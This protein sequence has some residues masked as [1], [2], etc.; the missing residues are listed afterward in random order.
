MKILN[1]SSMAQLVRSAQ[2]SIAADMVPKVSAAASPATS[3]NRVGIWSHETNKDIVNVSS[4]PHSLT[5][6]PAIP[7][8]EAPATIDAPAERKQFG[9]RAAGGT[10]LSASNT[11]QQRDVFDVD[12]ENHHDSGLS[13]SLETGIWTATSSMPSCEHLDSDQFYRVLPMSFAQTRFWFLKHLVEDQTAFNV[14]TVV[15]LK[16]RVDSTRLSRAL[17]AVGTRHEAIRTAFFTNESDSYMQGVLPSL[18][19]QLEEVKIANA[20]NVQG[21]IRDI[22]EHEFDLSRGESIRL[23]LVSLREKEHW[24]VLGYHHIAVDGIG[25]RIFLSDLERA[26]YN[27]LDANDDSVLQYPDFSIRQRQEYEQGA[28]SKQIG[29]WRAQFPDLPPPLPVLHLAGRESRPLRSVFSSHSAKLVLEPELKRSIA[30]CCRRLGVTPFHFYLTVFGVLLFRQ[31]NMQASDLCIGVADGNRKDS[32][33]VRSLGLF[34]N[35]LPLRFCH[36]PDELFADTLRNVREKTDVAYANSRVPIDVLLEDLK[37]PRV[38]SH[39]PLF[40]AFFNYRQNVQDSGKYLGCEAA[41]ELISGGENAY[42]ISIDVLDSA[43]R[44]NTISV[45]VNS[46]IYTRQHAEVLKDSYLNLL[47]CFGRNPALR[48]SGCPLYLSD[49]VEEAICHGKGQVQLSTWS[50]TIVDRIDEMTSLY[51]GK[52]ALTDGSRLSLTYGD[53]ASR[54]SEIAARLSVH[55]IGPGA[56]VGIYQTPGPDWICSLLGVLRTAASCVPLDIAVGPA[57]LLVTIQDCQA[58]IILIDATTASHSDFLSGIASRIEDVS[59]LSLQSVSGKER[60]ASN[61]K[62]RARPDGAAF[63]T[64]TSGS[65]GTPKGVVIK[66]SSYMNFVEHGPPIWGISE[67]YEV[68]LQQSS[69]AFDMSLCQTLVCLGWGGTLVVPD[70]SVRGDPAAIC[71]LIV[72]QRITFT[73]ATPTEYLAWMRH[74]FAHTTNMTKNSSAIERAQWRGA[75]SGGEPVTAGLLQAFSASVRPGF[76]FINCYGPCETT[77]ACAE[78]IQFFPLDTSQSLGSKDGV[79][80]VGT[81]LDTLSPLPNCFICIVDHELKPVPAGVVGQVMIGGAGVAEGYLRQPLL[82]RDVFLHDVAS[83]T[84]LKDQCR[85]KAHLSGDLGWLDSNGR[86]VLQGRVDGSTQVKVGGIRMDLE[87]IESAMVRVMETCISQVV[88]SCRKGPDSSNDLLVAFVVFTPGAVKSQDKPG[89]LSELPHRL[90]LPKY[91]RPSLVLELL[92]IPWTLSNK[93]DRA[94]VDMI[95]LPQPL[96]PTTAITSLARDGIDKIGHTLRQLWLEVLPGAGIWQNEPAEGS[97]DFFHVG[98]SSLS[99]IRLQSLIRKRLDIALSI[100]QLFRA[101]RLDM[102]TALVR[103]SASETG[104]DK[105]CETNTLEVEAWDWG[106]EVEIPPGLTQIRVTSSKRTIPPRVLVLT[107]ATGLLGQDILRQLIEL[108]HVTKIYCLAIRKSREQLMDMPIFSHTK[109]VACPGDLSASRLGLSEPSA[110]TIFDEADAVIHAGADVS[111]LKTYTS[112]RPTNV[113]STKELARLSLPRRLPFHFISSASVMRLSGVDEM[114]PVSVAGFPPSR[115]STSVSS[116]CQTTPPNNSRASDGYNESKWVSEVFLENVAHDPNL[117]LPVVIHRPSSIIGAG[118]NDLDLMSSL[119]HYAQITA[120]V[121][122][123]SAWKGQLDFVSLQMAAETI[124]EHVMM[125]DASWSERSGGDGTPG[126]NVRFVYESGEVTLSFSQLRTH[127]ENSTG[128]SV[129]VLPF[130]RWVEVL[131]KAGMSGL[132][133]TYLRQLVSDG[134]LSLP[135]L[136]R[137]GT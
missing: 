44:E 83:H 124:L 58:Q 4:L 82:T 131:E 26:Y 74:G 64:Y 57:R 7:A 38:L 134:Q 33:V 56:C 20:A 15:H 75:M 96:S 30:Q 78:C 122:D 10:P 42:D 52:V 92:E 86:L 107:G 24:L 45:S 25:N 109:V 91:M 41:G 120:T 27:T 53:M 100:E 9:A 3:G 49:K 110:H 70:L 47:G 77:F 17:T 94:A 88:V 21:E 59:K 137:E 136:S 36:R 111:F 128:K 68:I 105:H 117:R 103:E 65:T 101:S 61:F 48:I 5:T 115:P 127:L 62:S 133:A 11:T 95:P 29:K 23:K 34:L 69:W 35:I 99:L 85:S 63:I 112:L 39:S 123:T 119:R 97:V 93:V 16:G 113:F 46:G 102:M 67:N 22:Q 31:T 66:H 135:R 129:T 55:G 1:A 125:T 130:M 72:S 76:R 81:A 84:F 51:Q 104:N 40:Q 73:L 80:A 13:G 98:G 14:T 60:G 118:P 126:P 71:Q 116:D 8:F 89:F 114:G 106:N 6:G 121:P 43:S 12:E 2:E 79:T 90:A 19:S 28:W 37:V 18:P 132:L 32:D 108:A 50:G 54:A 87:D